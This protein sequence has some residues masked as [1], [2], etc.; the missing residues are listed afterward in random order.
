MADIWF[1]GTNDNDHLADI[2]ATLKVMIATDVNDEFESRWGWSRA[3]R[4][5]GFDEKFVLKLAKRVLYSLD[6]HERA[7]RR[8]EAYS[9]YQCTKDAIRKA[10]NRTP[11]EMV[12]AG[13]I[14]R[15]EYDKEMKERRQPKF[16]TFSLKTLKRGLPT[17]TIPIVTGVPYV[18]CEWCV[19]RDST[20]KTMCALHRAVFEYLM[21]TRS[22]R[23]EDA[24]LFMLKV[25]MNFCRAA[26]PY[27][28]DDRDFVLKAATIAE[29][30]LRYA[31]R[32]LLD[33]AEIV[34]AARRTCPFTLHMVRMEDIQY[35]GADQ[36]KAFKRH[37]PR[38]VP[39]EDSDTVVE[40]ADLKRALRRCDD[41]VLENADLKHSVERLVRERER[42]AECVVCLKSARCLILHP[43]AHFCLCSECAAR[44]DACPVC[45]GVIWGSSLCIAV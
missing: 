27:L 13:R 40:N 17:E 39:E 30:S 41:L 25:D 29:R 19:Q 20:G 42:A 26:H 35:I 24:F 34:A 10:A 38:D 33:D 43:C 31:E 5:A 8:E 15:T 2:L 21:K 37:R 7:K 14:A 11:M 12:I 32:H 1:R 4:M 44:C 18:T 3:E 45:R 16:G 6:R 9:R 23:D 36:R 22:D 28:M